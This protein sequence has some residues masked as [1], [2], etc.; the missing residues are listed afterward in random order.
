MQDMAGSFPADLTVL[1]NGEPEYDRARAV[2]NLAG[3]PAPA[4]AVIARTVDE[5]RSAVRYAAAVGRP[6]R[7]LSTGH[8]SMSRGAMDDALLIRV[9]LTDGLRIDPTT[10]TA[11]VPAGTRWEGVVTA[12]AAYSLTAL[13]GSSSTVGAVGHLLHGG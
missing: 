10:R 9:E 4:E 3:V 11:W 6:V 13:H 2:F 12:A 1:R 8:G 7:V 5:V